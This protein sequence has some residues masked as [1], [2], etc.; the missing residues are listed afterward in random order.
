MSASTISVNLLSLLRVADFYNKV[1][2]SKLRAIRHA[3]RRRDR[4]REQSDRRAAEPESSILL[5]LKQ[6]LLPWNKMDRLSDPRS[7]IYFGMARTAL[8][9]IMK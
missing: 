6:Q 9:E 3:D 5:Q 1:F 4:D 8:L 2:M 7:H